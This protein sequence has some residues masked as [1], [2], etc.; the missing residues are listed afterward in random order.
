MQIAAHRFT[1]S[2]CATGHLGKGYT[3]TQDVVVWHASATP[4]VLLKMQVG[5]RQCA[6]ALGRSLSLTARS[7]LVVRL[8][9]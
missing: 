8:A 2:G 5:R 4:D 3:A 6:G 7:V 1:S 9:E